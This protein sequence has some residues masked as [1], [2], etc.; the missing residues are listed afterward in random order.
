MGVRGEGVV[1]L[2][3]DVG[4]VAGGRRIRLGRGWGPWCT[5]LDC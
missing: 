4:V 2:G 1:S 3:R 5:F